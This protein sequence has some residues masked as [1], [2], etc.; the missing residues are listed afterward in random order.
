MAMNVGTTVFSQLMAY[1]P[2]HEFRR[3][4]KRY[5]G[6]YKIKTFSCWDQFLCM[7]FAQLTYRESQRDTV[8]CL[9]AFQNKLYHMGFRGKISRNNLSHANMK[10]DW[11]IYADFAQVLIHIARKLYRDEEFGIELDETVYALDST[12]IDL[13]LSLFPWAKFR[14]QKGAIKLHILF[15]LRDNIPS[16]IKITDGKFHDVYILDELEPEPGSYYIMDR[17]YIDFIRLYILNLYGAFFVTRAKSNLKF[18]RRYSNPV[19][20][21]I[22]LKCDQIIVLTGA[23]SYKNYPEKLRRIKY[24]DSEKNKSFIF[25]TNNFTLPAIIVAQL[26]KY[27]WQVELFFKWIKQHLRIKSF[28][29]TTENAV[30][31]QIWIA[32]SVYILISIIK[33]RLKLDITLYTFLQI[34]SVSVLEKV[35]ILQL[36]T[37]SE[38][39]PLKERICNQ[40]NLFK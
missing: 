13:C 31:I 33:K 20:K 7:A 32:I 26:Y 9:R 2:M 16:F 6:D 8:T 3:C 34:L 37:N 17:A 28:F 10:R 11:R 40:L 4:V 14:K 30:K 15:D 38:Q 24:F 12:T 22:G 39:K 35:P 29:G 27:R 18:R 1:L 21:S 19:D 36:V 25:L 5:R 23:E